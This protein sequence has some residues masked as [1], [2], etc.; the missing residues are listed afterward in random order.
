MKR[1]RPVRVPGL[2]S[3]SSRV[4]SIWAIRPFHSWLKGK[5]WVGTSVK[6]PAIWSPRVPESRLPVEMSMPA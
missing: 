1:A 3:R 2:C 6:R 5:G 4:P